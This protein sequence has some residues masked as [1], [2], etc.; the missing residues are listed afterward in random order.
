MKT[1][2]LLLLYIIAGLFIAGCNTNN[3]KNNAENNTE[4]NAENITNNADIEIYYFHYTRRCATC[5]AIE[6]ITKETINKIYADQVNS[7]KIIFKS[8]NLDEDKGE[9]IGEK[10]EVAGQALI[11]K[12]DENKIDLTN[13]AFM[14][15]KSKP[16]KLEALVKSTIDKLLI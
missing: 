8:I 10:L 9:K 13:D 7:G 3:T 1:K 2:N 6:N 15:A 11:I 5:N 16:E 4:S 12:K 14:Y